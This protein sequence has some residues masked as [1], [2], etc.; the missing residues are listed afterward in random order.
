MGPDF[1]GR[2]F[3]TDTNIAQMKTF[4][5]NNETC[6]FL[7]W[8]RRLRPS[9]RWIWLALLTLSIGCSFHEV[10]IALQRVGPAPLREFIGSEAANRGYLVVYSK[11]DPLA[12][13]IYGHSRYTLV[14]E[15]AKPIQ[16]VK[17]KNHEDRYGSGPTHLALPPGRLCQ[18]QI[19]DVSASD[20]ENQ[21][22]HQRQGGEEHHHGAS[23]ARGQRAGGF[24]AEAA[25]LVGFGVGLAQI[26]GYNGQF[27]GGLRT[28]DAALQASGNLDPVV[29]ARLVV[30]GVGQQLIEVA[31]G[32]P[33]LAIEDDV[34]AA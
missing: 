17:V 25:I 3:L 16:Q 2:E 10:P 8:N 30:A 23:I 34:Q 33:E 19:G 20:P 13:D 24:E 28:G 6:Q 29:V 11:P 31:E 26:P 4:A 5:W 1:L 15:D 22:H 32:D 9:I 27:G 7:P 14:S 18:K 21:Q 12:D